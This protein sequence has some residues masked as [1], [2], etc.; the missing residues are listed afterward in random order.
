MGAGSASIVNRCSL[1]DVT[2]FQ[3]LLGLVDSIPRA[4]LRGCAAALCPGLLCDCPF[5]AR[6]GSLAHCHPHPPLFPPI[7]RGGDG[8]NVRFESSMH[9][10]LGRRAAERRCRIVRC[11]FQKRLRLLDDSGGTCGS[12]DPLSCFAIRCGDRTDRRSRMNPPCRDRSAYAPHPHSAI[13]RSQLGHGA[14]P[15][16][17]GTR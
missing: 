12:D 2:P 16:C 7:K 8:A 3:G 14:E 6:R 10:G 5:G 9:G 15:Y 1:P 4:T 17:C 11:P 13:H